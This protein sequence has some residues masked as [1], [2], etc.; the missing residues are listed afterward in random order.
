MGWFIA[1]DVLLYIGAV[2]LFFNGLGILALICFI[3]AAVLT[4]ILLGINDDFSWLILI[5][6]I[7]DIFD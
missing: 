7:T 4:F 1:L 2:V 5:D 6:T 3:L